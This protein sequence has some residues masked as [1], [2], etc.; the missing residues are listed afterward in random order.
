[1][2]IRSH[3]GPL[4]EAIRL[5]TFTPAQPLHYPQHAPPQSF[6][7]LTHLITLGRVANTW[8]TIY[9]FQKWS[10]PETS[11]CRRLLSSAEKLTLRKACY[12]LWLYSLAWHHRGYGRLIR[13]QSMMVRQRAAMLRM[14]STEELAEMQDLQNIFRSILAEHV[15]PS[16]GNVLRQFKE[17]H[18]NSTA[19]ATSLLRVYS[20]GNVNLKLGHSAQDLPPAQRYDTR[21]SN[22]LTSCYPILEGWGDEIS[23]YYLLEDMLK[24]NPQQILE[25]YRRV[26]P[27]E[28]DHSYRSWPSSA[29]SMECLLTQ[30]GCSADWFE[31]N[32]ETFAGTAQ[33]VVNDRGGEYDLFRDAIETEQH[34]I[35]KI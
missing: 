22:T 29:Q 18:P 10:S 19:A 33:T 25:L 16:N 13:N 35:V 28:G 12:R 14:W 17:C 5:A 21:R 9:P 27:T 32:G 6:A 2:L 26:E 34:G 20:L 15:C 11:S 30:W 24:L 4:P 31:N 8:A 7:L 3:P 23:H 1:M